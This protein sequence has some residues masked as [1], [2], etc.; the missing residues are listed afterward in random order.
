M[1]RDWSH[2]NLKVFG[3][4]FVA[5]ALAACSSQP[6][7]PSASAPAPAAAVPA[8]PAA[9]AAP[10]AGAPALAA[11]AV[12]PATG[13]PTANGEGPVLSRTLIA[14]GYK[15][16]AVGKEVYYC[17]QEMV[18]GTTFKRKVCLNEAQL[19]NEERK[20]KEMQEQMMRT[21]ASPPCTPMPGCAG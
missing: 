1:R 16:T 9:A 20:I 5:I 8:A 19:R 7:E 6:T 15:A 3:T 17:R 12:A 21:Q 13:T 2:M 14:A 11:P 4:A 10:A 18:T